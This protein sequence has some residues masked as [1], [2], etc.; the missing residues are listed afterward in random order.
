MLRL[1]GRAFRDEV[2]DFGAREENS[3]LGEFGGV[4]GWSLSSWFLSV[5][6]GAVDLLQFSVVR[7]AQPGGSGADRHSFAQRCGHGAVRPRPVRSHSL[8]GDAPESR[9]SYAVRDEIADW[10]RPNSSRS[11]WLVT[12]L[13]ATDLPVA[14]TIEDKGEQFAGGRDLADLDATSFTDPTFRSS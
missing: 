11:R 1:S 13:E 14:Q 8:T 10:P 4:A 7:D 2:P 5:E 6:M 3:R 9:G 12:I